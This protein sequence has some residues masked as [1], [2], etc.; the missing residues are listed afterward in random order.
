MII[1][2]K[3]LPALRV[4]SNTILDEY[5]PK[6]PNRPTPYSDMTISIDE[7]V[8]Q[9]AMEYEVML[10]WTENTNTTFPAVIFPWIR[11][12]NCWEGMKQFNKGKSRKHDG[13]DRHQQYLDFFRLHYP[14]RLSDDQFQAICNSY[15]N[16]TYLI[17]VSINCV[18][19]YLLLQGSAG[20][21]KSTCIVFRA[22]FD[23]FML[24][25]TTLII[26]ATNPRC[27]HSA[28]GR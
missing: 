21:G 25:R 15:D 18:I 23:L 12:F 10:E 1:Y 14:I 24:K 5:G 28:H 13:N 8:E 19:V 6:L 22:L 9:M 2:C 17:V 27:L 11:N 20:T 26:T 16:E 7:G 3:L 4:K